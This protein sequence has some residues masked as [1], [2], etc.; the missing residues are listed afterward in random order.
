[1]GPVSLRTKSSWIIDGRARY[2]SAADGIRSKWVAGDFM[3]LSEVPGTHALQMPSRG[4]FGHGQELTCGASES[5]D[6][7][8]LDH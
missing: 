7:K 6:Q 5:Y 8:Q 3:G 1:M 2:V 4:E